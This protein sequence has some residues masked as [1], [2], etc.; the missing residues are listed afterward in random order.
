MRAR[1]LRAISF[2]L[3]STAALLVVVRLA[4]GWVPAVA[5]TLAY[6][7][8]LLTRPRMVRVMRRLRGETVDRSGYFW[9]E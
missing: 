7:V 4:A 2:F 9:N 6:A 5:V 3:F 1:D 8:W